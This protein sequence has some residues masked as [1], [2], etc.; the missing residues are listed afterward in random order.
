[1]SGGR[2]LSTPDQARQHCDCSWVGLASAGCGAVCWG[3]GGVGWG[4]VG[5]HRVGS[6]RVEWIGVGW[7]GVD[8]ATRKFD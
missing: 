4:V 6:G 8:E 3:R 1:M 5:W 2:V 7:G